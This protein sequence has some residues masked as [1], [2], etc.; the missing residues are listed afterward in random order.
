M[1]LPHNDPSV[2]RHPLPL[3]RSTKGLPAFFVRL[4]VETAG[5]RCRHATGRCASERVNRLWFTGQRRSR[6]D[7]TSLTSAPSR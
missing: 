5:P 4:V 7:S 1:R 2:P 3:E 6:W